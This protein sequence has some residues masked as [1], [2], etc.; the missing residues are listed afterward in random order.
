VRLPDDVGG[1]PTYASIP[2]LLDA[3]HDGMPDA[4]ERRHGFDPYNPAD[5]PA[6]ADKDGYTNLEEY[7]NGTDP[8]VFVDYTDPANN[9]NTLR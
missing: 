5:G 4:W 8:R 1:W 3:D 2:A 7:L 9:V 6:D